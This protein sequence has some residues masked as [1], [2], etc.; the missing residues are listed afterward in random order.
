MLIL[1][2]LFT[3]CLDFLQPKIAQSIGN[4]G[5]FQGS[6]LIWSSSLDWVLITEYISP[7][8]KVIRDFDNVEKFHN[9]H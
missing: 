4:G 9:T 5:V 1:F 2:V 6:I 3:M 7:N 8:Y